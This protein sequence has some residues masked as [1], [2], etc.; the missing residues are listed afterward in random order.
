MTEAKG[1][2]WAAGFEAI[3]K[4]GYQIL[5]LPD[6]NNDVL[7]RE[8]K[9]PVYWW[10]PNEVRLARR[11]G[12]TGDYLFSML[13]FVGV[14]SAATHVGAEGKEEVAGG[15]LGFS[16]TAAPPGAI[17]QEATN[18]LIEKFRGSDT[19]YWGW[20]TPATPMFRPAPI[21]SNVTS[22][23]DLNPMDD[24]TLPQPQPDRS[25]AGG[26][27]RSRA[28]RLRASRPPEFVTST[29]L[30]SRSFPRSIPRRAN[31]SVRSR[32]LDGWYVNLKGQ[33]NGTVTPFAIN[34]YSGLLGTYPAA[35]IW[36]TFHGGSAAFTV[37][38]DMMIRVWSPVVTLTLEGEWDRVQD[39]FS[40]A[41]HVGGLFWGAD[42]Q[43]EFNNLAMSGGITAKCQVDRSL[44]D[45]DKLEAELNKRKDVVFQTFMQQAQKT[46]FD[47]AP[48]NE[49]PAEASGGF[50]GWGAG[51]AFKLRRDKTHLKLSYKEETE[52]AYLQP[53]PIRGQLEGLHAEIAA[54][55]AAEKKY[56]RT[57]YMSDWD[58]KV[59]RIVKPV[60]N[61]PNPTQK[62]VGEPVS[63]LSVQVGYPNTEGVI[64]WDNTRFT[65][66][67]PPDAQWTSS[68]EMKKASDVKN[69]PSGWTPDKAFIKRKIH[70]LEPPN[71]V[72]FP[73]VR[74]QVERNEVDLDPGDFGT[75]TADNDVEVRVDNVGSLMLGPIELEPELEGKQWVEVTFQ[76]L[77]KTHDGKDRPPIRFTWTPENQKEGRLWFL[78]TGQPDFIPKYKYQVRAGVRGT[79]FGGGQAWTG[80]WDDNGGNGPLL[81]RVPPPD[82]EGVRRHRLNAGL[83]AAPPPPRRARPSKDVSGPPPVKKASSTKAPSRSKVSGYPV[84]GSAA[85]ARSA[86]TVATTLAHSSTG[87]G[88]PEFGS[89]SAYPPHD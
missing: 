68:T 34:S 6:V 43:M 24:G 10:L 40:A 9:A 31:D 13:H 41:A 58:R 27:P 82:G 1:P 33:G 67:D 5:F 61:W 30:P 2:I 45:A 29:R 49:K 79:I 12:D 63:Y 35:M 37:Y 11:N 78:F 65:P 53:F 69:A 28:D 19:A 47:P 26:P 72:E 14:R 64:Q 57:L 39:H 60:V 76:A 16:T 3:T 46:I 21:M 87:N 89:F 62:W 84:G 50:L 7:Q 77:G 81:V 70:F 44:P 20:R 8:G 22:V 85:V 75:L 23:T 51:A 66:N 54:D 83:R 32:G 42:L 18:G 15:L 56:F 25:P 52:Y 73:Y 59:S 38:Q 86:P 71:E 88:E 17:L 36:E 80:P 4:S 48:Y 74:I 55:P